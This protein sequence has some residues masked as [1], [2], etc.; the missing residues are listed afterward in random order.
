MCLETKELITTSPTRI[1]EYHELAEAI[2][3]GCQLSKPLRGLS[4]HIFANGTYG[5]CVLGACAMGL[6]ARNEGDIARLYFDL[7]HSFP[8]LVEA[9]ARFEGFGNWRRHRQTREQI[10]DWLDTL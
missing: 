3:R 9:E 7:P 6:G 2:R 4:S 1:S 5:T 10:A 8:V